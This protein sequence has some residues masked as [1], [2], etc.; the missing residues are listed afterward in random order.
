MDNSR[1]CTFF[2]VMGSIM[3]KHL[4]LG[5]NQRKLN[6][7]F[8][9]C[10]SRCKSGFTHQS[11]RIPAEPGHL[12]ERKKIEQSVWCQQEFNYLSVLK[13]ELFFFPPLSHSVASLE[14]H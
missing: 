7:K 14:T 4:L 13:L 5:R 1:Q 2:L 8:R 10:C 9:S 12:K 11:C 3:K 6:L